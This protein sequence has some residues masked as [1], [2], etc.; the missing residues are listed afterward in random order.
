MNE[1]RLAD[2]LDHMQQAATDACSFVEGLSK[3]DFLADKLTQQGVIMSLIIIG[4]ASTKIMDQHA[5]FVDQHP[6]VP[7]RSMR[8]MR[9][10]IAHGYFDINLDVVW[11][12]V[13]TALTEL[14]EQLARL[15]NG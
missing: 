9:N 1:D 11:A 5:E 3:D 2:Y 8:G 15:R 6:E 7:W 4:E 12:T 14:L 13:Q 10:R